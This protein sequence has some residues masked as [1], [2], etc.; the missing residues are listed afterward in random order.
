MKSSIKNFIQWCYSHAHKAFAITLLICSVQANAQILP[1]AVNADPAVV[2]ITQIPSSPNIIGNALLQFRFANQALSSNSTGQIPVASIRLTIS[3]PGK[4]AFTSVNSI[5]KFI[6]EDYDDQPFGVVHLVNSQ[7]ILEGEQIDLLL[8]VRGTETGAGT[9]TFNVDRIT[10]AIVANTSTANDNTQA[11]FTTTGVLPLKLTSFSAMGVGCSAK[12]SWTTTAEVNVARYDVLRSTDGGNTFIT[13]GTVPA[14]IGSG[15]KSYSYTDQMQGTT[16]HLYRLKMV[17]KN[18]SISYSSIA[19]INSG[20]QSD[21]GYVKVYPSPARS[22]ITLNVSNEGLMG[23]RAS[24]ID[25]SG[26][27]VKMFMISGTATPIPVGD[28]LAGMYM[29]RLSDN[30]T[31]KF[32]K[33]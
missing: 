28:L 27:T 30:T 5:P 1:N 7:L 15:D 8:N 14:T 26:R 13:V 32:I 18:G 2:S 3:F 29:I 33:E 24:M 11:I 20:C 21:N 23:T 10:P 9:V 31:V 19:R 4:F 6:V 16:A 22:L 17:D 12:I 25:M